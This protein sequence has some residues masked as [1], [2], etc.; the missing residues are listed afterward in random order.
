MVLS[1]SISTD[2]ET[3]LKLKAAAAGVDVQ[4]FAARTLE[5]VASRPSLD[6][7]LTPLRAEFE[8]SGMNED[9]LIELLESAKHEMRAEMRG[10]KAS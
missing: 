5:R 1:I 9:Q 10:R 3:K 2:T 4:T 8:A 6:D 7:L